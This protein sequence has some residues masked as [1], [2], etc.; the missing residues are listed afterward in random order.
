VKNVIALVILI[1]FLL[2][3]TAFAQVRTEDVAVPLL[4]AS[5]QV[6]PSTEL[7]SN[8]TDYSYEL[9]SLFW[10]LDDSDASFTGTIK[11]YQ[12]NH[13]DGPYVQ[14]VTKVTGVSSPTI[15]M[16]RKYNLS[17]VAAPS[18][19]KVKLG[20]NNANGSASMVNSLV[21][22]RRHA[23]EASSRLVGGDVETPVPV[24]AAGTVFTNGQET[25]SDPIPSPAQ[26]KSLD[27][28]LGAAGATTNVTLTIYTSNVKAGPYVRWT[29]ASTVTQF[30]LDDK[31]QGT[32]LAMPDTLWVKFGVDNDLGSDLTVVRMTALRRAP[33]AR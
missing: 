14:W 10:K 24:F 18:S 30:T 12:A 31:R 2:P 8:V 22:L 29:P 32:D 26:L 13:K 19:L 5:T 7:F 15:T 3:W 17:V 25:Y 27:W 4:D 9:K 16:S 6:T 23:L 28:N 21:A 33:R 20:I 1:A 11:V